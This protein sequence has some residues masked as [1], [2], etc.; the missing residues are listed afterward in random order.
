MRGGASIISAHLNVP[1]FA[2]VHTTYTIL[3]PQDTPQGVKAL[4]ASQVEDSANSSAAT[5]VYAEFP[6]VYAE[7]SVTFRSNELASRCTGG[8]T[9]VGPDEVVLGTGPSVTTTLD[10]KGN[11]WAVALAGP[12]WASGSSDI[13]AS[14]TSPPFTSFLTA[15]N[16]LSSRVTNP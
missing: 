2:T 13:E 14:L 4:P 15:F 7:K 16:I 10:N 1:P 9:W 5:I 8:I 3:P 12:S 11:A 6:S